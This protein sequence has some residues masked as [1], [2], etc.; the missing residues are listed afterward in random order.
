MLLSEVLIETIATIAD[1]LGEV[2]PVRLLESKDR[3]FVINA[4]AL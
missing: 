3:H 1:R 4:K 2:S